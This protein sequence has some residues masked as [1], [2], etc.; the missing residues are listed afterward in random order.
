MLVSLCVLSSGHTRSGSALL[1]CVSKK[2]KFANL[3]P[4]SDVALYMS[5]SRPMYVEGRSLEEEGKR[6]G[7]ERLAF[8]RLAYQT[9]KLTAV[10]RKRTRAV[11]TFTGENWLWR[12]CK[13]ASGS[14]SEG[15]HEQSG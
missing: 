4:D 8:G 10:Q 2:G 3:R 15:A 6:D 9:A 14:L 7:G 11:T 1:I 12:V 13:E 5:L